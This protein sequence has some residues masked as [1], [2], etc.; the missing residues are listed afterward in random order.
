V[1]VA[2]V[3]TPEATEAVEPQTATALG[4]VPAAATA[5]T[6]VF[7]GDSPGWD[8]LSVD[9]EGGHGRASGP[10]DPGGRLVSISPKKL[11]ALTPRNIADDDI[12]ELLAG[13]FYGDDYTTEYM[14]EGLFDLL[15]Q[16]GGG[17]HYGTSDHCSRE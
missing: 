8:W 13:R 14:M 9:A 1:K 5:V 11:R 2:D 6:R 16:G 7:S 3:E 12:F 17:G 4:T 15:F 10:I